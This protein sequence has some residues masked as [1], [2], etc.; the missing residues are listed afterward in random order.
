[1][2]IL[3]EI[4]LIIIAAVMLTAVAL[5]ESVVFQ[6]EKVNGIN[7]KIIYVDLSDLSVKVTP[8]VSQNFPGTNENFAGMLHRSK[9]TAAINGTYFCIRTL[10]PVGDIVIDGKLV[11]YGGFGTVMAITSDNKVK[12]F[13]APWGR[14]IEWDGF[15]TVISAGPRLLKAGR[16]SLYPRAEGFRDPRVYSYAQRSA[17]GVTGGNKLLL[18]YVPKPVSLRQLA[19]IMKTLDCVEAMALDGGSSTGL[20]YRGKF[21]KKPGRKLTNLLLVY[22]NFGTRAA[23]ENSKISSGEFENILDAISSDR[24]FARG[25]RMYWCGNYEEAYRYLNEASKGKEYPIYFKMVALAREVKENRE[26]KKTDYNTGMNTV[27]IF[28]GQ[29]KREE[30]VVPAP[31][32]TPDKK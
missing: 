24:V 10:K 14:R 11:N 32:S 6:N 16:V 4:S 9:P 25:M 21:I 27:V 5:A 20:F 15:E 17:V 30:S 31:T 8:Q 3:L 28:Y 2:K 29:S 23:R 26:K 19:N 12:F 22:Q 18:V 13:S 7:V 1:M